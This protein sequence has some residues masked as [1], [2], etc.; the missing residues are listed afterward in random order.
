[1]C[2]LT[3]YRDCDLGSITV[4]N[5]FIDDFLSDANDCQIKVYLY[6]IRMLSARQ[7]TNISDIADKFNHTEK[8]VCRA[9]KYWEKKGILSLDYEVNGSI[10]GIRLH[11]PGAN[12]GRTLSPVTSLSVVSSDNTPE[13]VPARDEIISVPVGMH[14]PDYT[15]A[16]LRDFKNR[17]D[18]PQLIFV[19]ETY[20]KKTLSAGDIRS[21]L[22]YSD[23]L[24]FSGELIDYLLQFCLS[25]GK[26]NFA[27]MDKV[28][29]DWAD[30]DI[31]T[32]KKAR[33]YT[34]SFESASSAGQTPLK[35]RSS[36]GVRKKQSQ[37]MFHQFE[38]NSYDF[39]SLERQLLQQ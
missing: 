18:T 27:Y 3:L 10:V 33:E 1:M 16:D 19:A 37:T 20:L 25:R 32:V 36:S 11:E 8:D 7:Q 31:D 30:H 13:T 17:E 38:Q 15:A 24:G 21:L 12:I 6:L 39:S 26:R 4:S 28:A 35:S 9:L 22:F 23:A 5:Y 34:S 2:E 14:K 29:V